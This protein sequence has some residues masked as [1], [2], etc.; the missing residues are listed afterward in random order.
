MNYEFTES[1]QEKIL[2]LLWRDVDSY[3][4]YNE[5]IKPK[6]FQSAVHIDLA[7]VIFDYWGEYEMPP[8][9]EVLEEE[10]ANLTKS[11][12]K[13]GQRKEYMDTID[14]MSEMSLSDSMYLKDK[15]LEFG[16]RQA[17]TEAIIESA[18]LIEKDTDSYKR[19]EE[20]VKDA[21]MVGTGADDLGLFLLDNLEERI[22]GYNS[23]EDVI[24]RIPSANEKFNQLLKGGIGKGE[25]GVVIASP[26]VGKTTFLIENA[27]AAIRNGY[28]VVHYTLENDERQIMRN[29]DLRL[30]ERNLE[31]IKT[32]PMPSIAAMRNVVKVAKG[33]LVVKRYPTKQAS[34][35]TIRAHLYKLKNIKGFVP[36]MIVVDYGSL[37][38]PSKSNFNDVRHAISEVYEEIRGLCAEFNVAVWT[39]VQANR[40]SLAKK[41]I[42]IADIA[43]AFAV[44]NTADIMMA[45]CQ[46]NKEKQKGE[47]RFFVAKNR[48]S[49]SGL[50]FSG[51]VD[52]EI[53]RM[54]I[55]KEI[56]DLDDDDFDEEIDFD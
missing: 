37:L 49:V 1:I 11:K 25:M 9:L 51:K 16:K 35:D 53:K 21:L 33:N 39:A 56:V 48:D 26:G 2:A 13:K 12:L 6:Y 17:M 52:H 40:G 43:E 41:V 8:T 34:V 4:L 23:E 5:C 42:T 19:V 28:N 46:T 20:L 7:R 15:I 45:L 47:M 27:G 29:Y 24:P 14:K 55:D 18:D 30:L 54:T 36:D 10:V 22:E 38:R 31:Y 3:K 32:N 44:A 50:L